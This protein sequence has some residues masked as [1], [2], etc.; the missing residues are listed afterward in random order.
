[1]TART[2]VLRWSEGADEIHLSHEQAPITVDDGWLW[3]QHERLPEL[4]RLW[5]TFAARVYCDRDM[6]SDVFGL[7]QLGSTVYGSGCDS[8]A[9]QCAKCGRDIAAG[10]THSVRGELTGRD[11]HCEVR[12]HWTCSGR[13]S[14]A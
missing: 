9:I 10:E 8:V 4:R 12:E 13:S 2:W 1:M 6:H 14:E 11:Y 3:M 5:S 7:A